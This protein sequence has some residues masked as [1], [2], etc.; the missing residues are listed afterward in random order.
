MKIRNLCRFRRRCK[1]NPEADLKE[2]D[3]YEINPLKPEFN[4]GIIS[5]PFSPR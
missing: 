1:N 3:I 2:I 4:P 5:S